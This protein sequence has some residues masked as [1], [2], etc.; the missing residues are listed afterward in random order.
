MTQPRTQ[1]PTTQRYKHKKVH[2][3]HISSNV[4]FCQQYG[5]NMCPWLTLT[6]LFEHYVTTRGKTTDLLWIFTYFINWL[7][8]VL[9]I[10]DA[11]WQKP[12][13]T[14]YIHRYKRNTTNKFDLIICKLFYIAINTSH[15]IAS[16]GQMIGGLWIGNDSKGSGRKQIELHSQYLPGQTFRKWLQ[17]IQGLPND[18]TT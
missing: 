7:P 12:S 8:L 6:V 1:C 2:K 5:W 13:V 10:M 3:L 18:I 15:F 14:S 9:Q 16:N 11:Y 4:T 17:V